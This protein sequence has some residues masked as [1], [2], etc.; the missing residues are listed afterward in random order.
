MSHNGIYIFQHHEKNVAE[1]KRM[2]KELKKTVG[3]RDTE[4]SALSGELEDLNVSVNERRH[5]HEVNG[6]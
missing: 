1:K 6:T 5:I 3:D 4:N 2:L